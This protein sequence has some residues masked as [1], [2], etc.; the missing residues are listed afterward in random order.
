MV[1]A[2]IFP[3]VFLNAVPVRA[4]M[5]A[6]QISHSCPSPEDEY[7][8]GDSGECTRCPDNEFCEGGL[9]KTDDPELKEKNKLRVC[10][11]FKAKKKDIIPERLLMFCE[12]ELTK[13]ECQGC[14]KMEK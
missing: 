8:C 12:T 13:E 3:G 6:C 7:V 1:I 5:A 9:P 11:N 4:D 10:E 14:L 2:M